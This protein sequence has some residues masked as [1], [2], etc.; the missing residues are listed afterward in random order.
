MTICRALWSIEKDVENIDLHV[1]QSVITHYAIMAN[2]KLVWMQHIGLIRPSIVS[3]QCV[4]QAN[5]I[6]CSLLRCSTL[7]VKFYNQIQYLSG[8]PLLSL[9]FF[10]ITKTNSSFLSEQLVLNPEQLVLED[11]KRGF[12]RPWYIAQG[13]HHIVYS[14]GKHCWRSANWRCAKWRSAKWHGTVKSADD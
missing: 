13:Q 1:H 2:V 3:I 10:V 7:H 14:D 6:V 11:T 9:Q 12:F 8:L 5:K 4:H